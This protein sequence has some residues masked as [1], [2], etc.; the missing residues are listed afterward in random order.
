MVFHL[1]LNDSYKV[2]LDNVIIVLQF[3]RLYLYLYSVLIPKF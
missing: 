1:V 3:L 2:K